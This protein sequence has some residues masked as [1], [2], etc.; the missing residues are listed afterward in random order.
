MP[1]YGAATLQRPGLTSPLFPHLYM[2]T[3]YAYLQTNK[4]K[5]EVQ[6]LFCSNVLYMMTQYAY[7]R[8]NKFKGDTRWRFERLV[9]GFYLV[10][11]T[12]T[13]MGLKDLP[14]IGGLYLA[15]R[16]SSRWVSR[17][18]P[19]LEDFVLRS[20]LQP[21]WVSRICPLLEDFVSRS[22]L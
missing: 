10:Q 8:N 6:I 3:H 15:Q 18:C 21:R 5:H 13:T 20:G 17:I 11:Q 16:T 14:L 22:G 19:S 4:F 7:L 9:R 12:L 1:Q 2:M